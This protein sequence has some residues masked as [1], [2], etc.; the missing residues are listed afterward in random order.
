[1]VQSQPNGNDCGVFAIAFAVSLLFNL[2]PNKIIYDHNLMHQHLAEMF[3]SN[4]T[5]HFPQVIGI[6]SEQINYTFSENSIDI[7]NIAITKDLTGDQHG[8]KKNE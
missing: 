5:E 7:N 8:I 4:R 6:N 3:Q 2:Q 1:M